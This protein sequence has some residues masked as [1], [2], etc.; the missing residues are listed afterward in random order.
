MGSA[1]T[2]VATEVFSYAL[3]WTQP[4][5]LHSMGEEVGRL[6]RVHGPHAAQAAVW[7]EEALNDKSQT[8]SALQA[9]TYRAFQLY[10]FDSANWERELALQFVRLALAQ[11]A[12]T[13][14]SL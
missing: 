10:R 8:S 14:R 3:I 7:S 11:L 1:R 5:P 2:G 6:C 4:R 13:H 9:D 12:K